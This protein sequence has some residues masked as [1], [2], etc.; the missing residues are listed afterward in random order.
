VR[1]AIAT[2]VLLPATGPADEL[3][4]KCLASWVVNSEVASVDLEQVVR[5]N[6]IEDN[7]GVTGSLQWLYE[8]TTAPV[9]AFLHSDT[10]ILEKG[11]DER[12][13][14]EFDDPSVG[15]VGFGGGLQHGSEDIY[16]TPYHLTQLA[17]Y[18]YL[19]NVDDA[20]LHGRRF[21]ESRDVAVLDGFALI[22][23]REL[24]DRAGGWP[25]QELPF[26]CYDY[27]AAITA[28]KFGYR[29]RLVGVSCV[30]HG[31]TTSTT[32][33]AQE[34]WQQSLGKT[35]AAIH[36]ESHKWL[37]NYGRGYLPWRCK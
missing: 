13:L 16:K 11:W 12:V 6:R 27:W 28:H 21:T 4:G 29:V 33:A 8:N 10:E 36:E 34:Y 3:V 37:Y 26:H 31:G 14:R 32:S 24:L 1:L 17:R 20:D 5:R 25:V 30:H 19:S 15:L 23:R 22:M 35:D 7:L 18:D 9:I 2:A